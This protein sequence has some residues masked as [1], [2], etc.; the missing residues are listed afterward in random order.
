MGLK[1]KEFSS[2]FHTE[3]W[4]F[5]DRTMKCNIKV[6][7]CSLFSQVV[8]FFLGR[9]KI[10]KKPLKRYFFF[11]YFLSRFS[12]LL[13]VAVKALNRYFFL[14]TGRELT[15]SQ[16]VHFRF[17]VHFVSNIVIITIYITQ[18]NILF[19]LSNINLS[20]PTLPWTCSF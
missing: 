6:E 9:R 19:I 17:D 1:C 15:W 18:W 10:Y 16:S 13:L 4:G 12:P 14:F 3:N 11:L 7:P 2:T 5:C 20:I 8:F